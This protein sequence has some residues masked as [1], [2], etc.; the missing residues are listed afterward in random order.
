MIITAIM[1]PRMVCAR[2][3]DGP[4]FRVKRPQTPASRQAA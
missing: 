2:P 3:L 4:A 1:V